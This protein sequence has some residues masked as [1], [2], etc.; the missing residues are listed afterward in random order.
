MD[1]GKFQSVKVNIAFH[2]T[3]SDAP[4]VAV[5]DES[6]NKCSEFY[7]FLHEGNM[8]EGQVAHDV[9]VDAISHVLAPSRDDFP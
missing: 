3:L 7:G 8:P 2:K 5:K 1:S 4:K 9:V 6:L